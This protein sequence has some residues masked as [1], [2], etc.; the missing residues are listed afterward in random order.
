MDEQTLRHAS[1]RAVREVPN[2]EAVVLFGSRARG[3]AEEYSDWDLALLYRNGD[4][5]RVQEEAY[6]VINA[7][8]AKGDDDLVDLAALPEEEYRHDAHRP[9]TLGRGVY[10][11]GRLLAGEWEREPGEGEEMDPSVGKE[12]AARKTE[13]FGADLDATL[14][15]ACVV[16][17][18]GDG[19]DPVYAR[20]CMTAGEELAWLVA[21][22]FDVDTGGAHRLERTA[23]NLEARSNE[24]RGRDPD[25]A[26]RLDEYSALV[27]SLNGKSSEVHG[28]TF[29]WVA[30]G[31]TET[32]EETR[33]RLLRVLHGAAR[34]FGEYVRRVPEHREAVVTELVKARELIEHTKSSRP[35]YERLTPEVKEAV[36]AWL[37]MVERVRVPPPP[38]RSKPS[39]AGAAVHRAVGPKGSAQESG[40]ERNGPER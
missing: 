12:D 30:K 29:R 14:S 26:E 15:R 35:G 6:A 36:E 38:G 5:A 13:V 37:S 20:N 1:E 25:L 28:S 4:R 8:Q 21:F 39:G 7:E 2:L 11:D 10:L 9:A 23:E 3:D 24:V 33:S 16:A 32:P 34:F 22:A 40:R 18:R 31:E 17:Q 19:Y 27:R